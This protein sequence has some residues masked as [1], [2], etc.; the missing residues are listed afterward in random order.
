M[1]KPKWVM[2]LSLLG[3]ACWPLDAQVTFDRLLHS[4]NEPQNWL[5]YSGGYYSQRYSLLR[6]IDPS[7]AKN[8]ELKW[9]L[10][11]QVAGAWQSS[12]VVVDGI[13]YVTE[14]PNDV[15]AVDAKTGRVFWVYRYTNS[16]REQ[17]CCGA[18]N[19]G[20]AILG[21]TLFMGTLDAH[22]VAIDARNGK[23]LWN[24]A[25]ADD[26]L[27]YSITLQPL[28][29]KDKVIIGVGGAEYGIR[30]FVA[31]YNPQTGKEVWRFH[32]IPAA[33]E[34]GSETW[35]G[36]DWSHGGGS[37]WVTGS[38]DPTLNLT[39]WGVGNPGPD[40]N[41][42]Q[43]PGDN[44][45]T[46]SVV[47][48]DADTGKL[49]WHY[50][51]TPNDGYDYD[52]VQVPVLVDMNW[53]GSPAKLMMW[54]NRNGFFYVLDR[55][56]GRFLSGTPF[57]KVNWA[58]GFDEKGRPIATPPPPNM[59]VFPGNQGG[60]NWYSPSFSPRTEL[61]YVSAWE[62][63]SSTFRREA[64][65]YEPGRRFVGGGNQTVTTAP[66][67]PGIGIGRRNPINN[68]TDKV[69][70]GA[71]IAIDPRTGKHKWK[72]TQYDVT[73]SG[74]LTTA[75]DVLFTGGREGYFHALDART[76]ALLWKINLGA[77]IVNGPIT[78]QVDGKQ[79]VSVISGNVLTTFA[80][81][82]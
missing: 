31:A 10:Q 15:M 38:Y 9:V 22:L 25:V 27:A 51:F 34:P 73:D 30:G 36:E 61:F 43:R 75:S 50:Q 7:N 44:L 41:P 13:M 55:V 2:L 77:Q 11:N 45:Y 49:K 4:A 63:Y 17:V 29:V 28:I 18:N 35:S 67:A 71:V 66:D 52:A 21:D 57:V 56:T 62:N 59:P 16:G 32:T 39:Y 80:L 81:S 24:I 72:F 79:Y 1:R 5:S 20:V 19:R 8:L 33:G 76:G 47:A 58:S 40:W 46:D 54:A 14:R 69:G 65:A 48:L 37:I 26:K 74:I 6:Q 64:Q 23:P 60:T 42:A 53:N 70:N 12:P 78:Y 68:W 3:L 82:D